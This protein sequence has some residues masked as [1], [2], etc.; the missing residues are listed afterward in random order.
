[1]IKPKSPLYVRR[2][3]LNVDDFRWWAEDNSITLL[4][5]LH[6]TIAFSRVAVDWP[7]L[8]TATNT[9]IVEGNE[10]SI[11]HFGE[12]TVLRV[13]CDQ[14]TTRH[15]QFLSIGASWDYPDYKPHISLSTQRL[16]CPPYYG[17]IILGPEIYEELR[18]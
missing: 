1:M 2:D 17:S 16:D 12:Y 15:S 4:D 14:L 10:R 8:P 6:V 9:I 11:D 18:L 13:F 7:A 3:V 5:D